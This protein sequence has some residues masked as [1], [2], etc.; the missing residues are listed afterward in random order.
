MGSDTAL[1]ALSL[2]AVIVAVTNDVPRL[3]VV[4]V[5][6]DGLPSLP[7]AALD[8]VNDLTLDRGMRRA[9]AEQTGLDIRYAEQ[10]YTFGDLGRRPVV[11]PYRAVSVAYIALVEETA[12]AP[13]AVWIDWYALLP[14]EDHRNGR[15][16][17]LGDRIEPAL[18]AWAGSDAQRQE[19]V[20]IAF[21][22]PWDGVRVLE[23]YELLYELGLTA[24]RWADVGETAAADGV[25]QAMPFDHRRIAA[26]A[27]GRIRG[28]LTYRPVVFDLL[29]ETF[30]LLALQRTVEALAGV[31]VHKQ[32]FRRLVERSGL[33]QGTGERAVSHGG[34]PAELFRYRPEVQLEQARPGFGQPYG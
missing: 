1:V 6:E 7:S 24:E 28:K 33:V 26:T 3:L 9:I 30:T 34:R 29:P 21:G 31:R 27:L 16:D 4:A 14:W 10:L 19:R 25:G 20:G 13:A 15:P 23:R 17:V 2:D 22:E 5:P 11:E 12:P 8:A 32:N 18:E